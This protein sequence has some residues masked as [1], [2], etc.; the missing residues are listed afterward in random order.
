MHRS[1]NPDCPLRKQGVF[2]LL[3]PY[4]LRLRMLGK[5]RID[6]QKRKRKILG[7]KKKENPQNS[8]DSKIR[9]YDP[10]CGAVPYMR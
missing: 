10:C 2:S 4:I 5:E 6:A 1:K 8:K 3:N 7:R 9:D